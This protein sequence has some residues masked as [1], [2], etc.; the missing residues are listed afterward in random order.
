MVPPA[1]YAH[2]CAA[3]AKCHV[4]DGEQD[5][6]RFFALSMVKPELEKA[7]YFM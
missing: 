5:G 2:V 1:F 4:V 7:M 3:R 6:Q